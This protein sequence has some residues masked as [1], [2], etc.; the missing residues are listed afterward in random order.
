MGMYPIYIPDQ[1]V[2][3]KLVEQTHWLRLHGGLVMTLAKIQ[4]KYWIPRLRRLAKRAI[5]FCYGCKR[6]QVRA[7]ITPPP[8]LLPKERTQGMTAF[9]VVGVDFAGPIR[10]CRKKNLEGK[11]Y[12]VL[13]ACSLIRA[14]HL[15]LLLSLETVEF[16]GALKR[17]IARRGRPTKI[18]SDN[19]KTFAAAAE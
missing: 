19:G 5:N 13:F 6:F 3:H 4:E 17:F 9:E 12:L 16:L 7:L 1:C 8:G 10:Y 15:E 18:F 2:C 14:L 11:C